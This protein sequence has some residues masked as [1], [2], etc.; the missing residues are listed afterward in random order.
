[1]AEAKEVSAEKRFLSIKWKKQNK[2]QLRAITHKEKNN[3]NNNKKAQTSNNNL[4]VL[5]KS[6]FFFNYD[7][8]K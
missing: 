3:D 2:I 6:F 8:K 4:S 7:T 5:L 1:M